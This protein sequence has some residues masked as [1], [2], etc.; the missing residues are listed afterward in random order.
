MRQPKKPKEL[1]HSVAPSG[2]DFYRELLDHLSDGVYFVDLERRIQYWNQGAERLTGYKSEELLG[3]FCHDDILCHVDMEG[4]RLCREGCPLTATIAD[5]N[6]RQASVFLRHKE[7]R[8]VPVHMRVQPLRGPD[9]SVIGAVEIFSDDSAHCEERRRIEALR[10]LAFLDHLTQLPNRRCL[11]VALDS[12]VVEFAAHKDPFGILLIDSDGF[13]VINDNYGHGCGDR[14]LQQIALTLA[15]ALRPSDTVGRWGGDEFMAIARN[16][17]REIL[18]GLAQRCV[19]L[20]KETSIH[21]DRE[22][23]IP[24]SISVGAA[25]SRPG[26]SAEQLAHRADALLYQSKANGPGHLTTDD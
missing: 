17:N 7:G 12:A 19:A 20:I 1:I 13:K 16:V 4:R 10:R 2:P 18:C 3:R 15:G 9:G 25:L 22:Q 21:S 24:L 26:E 8:R 23:V 6:H 11:E 14:A 5:G